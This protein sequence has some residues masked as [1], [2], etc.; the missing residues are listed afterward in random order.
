MAENQNLSV[1]HNL[2]W[3]SFIIHSHLS[4]MRS[5]NIGKLTRA[6]SW[7]I[8]G[9]ARK[10]WSTKYCIKQLLIHSHRAAYFFLFIEC[11]QT[12]CTMRPMVL[13]RLIPIGRPLH[14]SRPHTL[15]NVNKFISREGRS[16]SVRKMLINIYKVKLTTSA[17]EFFAFHIRS[18]RTCKLYNCVTNI[19]SDRFD[20]R[21]RQ[22][23]TV[24]A[25]MLRA[26]L[27]RLCAQVKIWYGTR[28]WFECV[29]SFIGALFLCTTP[30]VSQN[31]N[32]EAV[33]ESSQ[34]TKER[35]RWTVEQ[36]FVSSMWCTSALKLF[37]IDLQ[38]RHFFPFRWLLAD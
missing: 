38:N 20:H 2:W 7:S 9:G 13:V 16:R 12:H 8:G 32:S 17:K 35:P 19:D 30:C 31:K 28:M 23:K 34:C 21:A 36:F 14:P 10:R 5:P 22:K 15:R 37:I 3:Y 29:N 4:L 11:Q 1:K 24:K 26:A 18:D 25:T 27:R 6:L 33:E